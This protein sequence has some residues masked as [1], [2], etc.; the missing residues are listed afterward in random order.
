M[1]G[2]GRRRAFSGTGTGSRAGWSTATSAAGTLGFPTA[3]LA[4][5]GLHLPRFGV[6]AV[7]VDVLDGPHSRPLSPAR[8]RSA[9]GRP[10]G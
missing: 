5:D 4:L 7:L 9:C 10:S 2:P 8:P 6:Y 1:A 3:N